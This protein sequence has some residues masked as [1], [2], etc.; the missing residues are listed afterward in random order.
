MPTPLP[1]IDFKLSA[2]AKKYMMHKCDFIDFMTPLCIMLCGVLT[3]LTKNR[4]YLQKSRVK[5]ILRARKCSY[6]VFQS[7]TAIS[8]TRV[9]IRMSYQQSTMYFPNFT[10]VI[11]QELAL[12]GFLVPLRAL[13]VHIKQDHK[14]MLVA[15]LLS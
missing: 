3:L 6:P 13:R 12:P 8:T 1:C 5:L 7:T 15:H 11:Y 14:E 4:C 10:Y 2:N 9:S